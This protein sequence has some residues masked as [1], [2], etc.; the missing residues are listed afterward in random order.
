MPVHQF[1]TRDAASVAAAARLK[2]ALQRRHE[3]QGNA[4]LVATGGSS[5]AR[6]YAELAAADIAWPDV[7]VVLSDERWVPADHDDSNEK[8]VR[9]H[10]L[11]GRAAGASLQSL[12]RD[13]LTAE[14]ACVAVDRELR[15]R[16]LPFAAALLGM[17]SD[18]HI[19]SLFP[20]AANLDDGLDPDFTT[21]CVPVSTAA[22]P[23]P[24]IS[25]TLSAL[26]R[27]DEIVLLIFGDDKWQVVQDAL[28][29]ADAYP[30]SRL[31]KQK[32]APVH[33]CWAP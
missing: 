20:D 4:T 8:L 15:N 17:G 23:H 32:R 7:S 16:Y 5:P 13:G 1:D 29:S 6:C 26:S 31:L 10:L 24:R 22:S 19:A 21:L 28:S 9:D 11:Q 3:A 27:S 30:V 12:Y 25:L 2:A 18:G 14:Q 33:I